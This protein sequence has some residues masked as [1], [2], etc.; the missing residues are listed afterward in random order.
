M[1]TIIGNGMANY[2]FTN[3]SLDLDQYD[4]II[5]DDNFKEEKKNIL[6]CR[7]KKAKEYITANYK[8]QNILYVVTGSPFFFS[9]GILIAKDLDKQ[10]IKIIDNISSKK[11]IQSKLLIN[12]NDIDT[13]SLHGRTHIDL[14]KFLTNRYTFILC[15]KF[16]IPKIQ[17]A[18][19]FLDPNDIKT[20]IGY[21]LGYDD[22]V[23]Q[24]VDILSNEYERFDIVNY[25]YVLL[26][27]KLFSTNIL[28]KD[29][30]F[31]TQRGMITKEYKR[32]LSLQYLDLKPN[33]ILWDI[34]AGSGS[35]G[36]Q[37]Y[38]RYKVQTIFFENQPLRIDFIKQNLAK[39]K[40]I[41]TTILEGD[42]QNF[43]ETIDQ[44]PHRIFIG[45]G[46]KQVID[47]LP[48]LFDRLEKDGII[49]INAITLSNLTQ[50]INT[51]DKANIKYEIYS[52][53]I[54]T[55]KGDLNLIEPQRQMFQIKV[56][57]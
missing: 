44:N 2:D 19:K 22:E 1:V 15:D 18:I 41:N 35:C 32:N 46:G 27:E 51:L 48:Y 49:L 20:T 55:Y 3:I 50:M 57:K 10:Y 33:L 45:G 31:I 36:I 16:T 30:E 7:Y 40:V 21:K 28:S 25:P 4:T 29:D 53:S 13:I 38:K 42:A 52:I 12:D 34:G 39:H 54:T 37:A 5:C 17:D 56:I 11:Y 6:K 47:K 8:T 24:Q 23:I 14:Q 26:I 43:F 9:A